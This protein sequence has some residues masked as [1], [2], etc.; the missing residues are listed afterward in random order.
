[1]LL[2]VLGAFPFIHFEDSLKKKNCSPLDHKII[3]KKKCNLFFS[4]LLSLPFPLLLRALKQRIFGL[5][6][7]QLSAQAVDFVLKLLVVFNDVNHFIVGLIQ[8]LGRTVPAQKHS[9]RQQIQ[10]SH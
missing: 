5:Q 6:L 2:G 10:T 9:F 4:R 8:A 1:M 7:G 3:I